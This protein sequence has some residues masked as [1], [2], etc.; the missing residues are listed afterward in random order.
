MKRRFRH[1]GEL[2][3]I[4][5]LALLAASSAGWHWLCQCSDELVPP[6][7]KPVAHALVVGLLVLLTGT[8]VRAADWPVVRGDP[9]GTGVAAGSLPDKLE[10]LWTYKTEDAGFEATAVVA[11]GIVYVG[12]DNGTFHAVRL[13]DGTAVWTKKFDDSGFLAGAAI[14][15]E[16]GRLYVGDA[17]ESLRCLALADGEELWT[18]KL[19]AEVHAGPTLHDGNVLVTCEA[20]TLTC[21]DAEKGEQRWQFGIE[22]PLRCTPTL[23]EGRALLAGCDSKLHIIDVSD[24]AEVGSVAID[25]PTG[26]TAAIRGNMVYFGTEGG[27][28]FAIE[29][30]ANQPDRSRVVWTYRDPQHGQSIRSSAAV[31]DKLIVY[32]SQGKSAYALDP[33]TGQRKWQL[34]ERSHVDSSPAIAG[35]RVV[36]ATT[37]GKLQVVDTMGQEEWSFG[38]GGGFAASPI[39]VDGK[40]ILGNTDGTLYC[41][42]DPKP[43]KEL[44]S[45][46]TEITEKDRE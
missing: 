37:G 6:L 21:F 30:N 1:L 25:A 10:T 19:D 23:V 43:K 39:V 32:G 41:F 12:D 18:A 7:A 45:E 26:A 13:A 2:L 38:A 3:A 8:M 40:I 27:T 28:F 17:V 4:G 5:G 29:V 42:G 33:A 34:S 36:V 11:D 24:G 16:N 14:D 9:Q 31:T 35:R 22:A 46:N 44:T 15:L 20:G